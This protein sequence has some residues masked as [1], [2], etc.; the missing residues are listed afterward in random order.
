MKKLIVASALLSTLLVAQEY[1][2]V[3]FSESR[4]G[5]KQEA[6]SD[7]SM[8]IKSE[9][10][11]KFEK[12]QKRSASRVLDDASSHVVVSSNLPI[13]G[14]EYAFYPYVKNQVEADA[15][16]DANV[17][18]KAYK[19]KLTALLKDIEAL[20]KS[21]TKASSS[22]EKKRLYHKLLS[23]L[24]EYN[25]YASVA[26]IVGVQKIQTPSITKAEVEA[27]LIH[28]TS[29]LDSL[30]LAS[31]ELAKS[32]QKESVFLYPP[33][34][35][36][37]HEVSEFAGALYQHLKAH[38]KTSQH[39]QSAK[40]ILIGDYLIERNKVLVNYTLLDAQN[41]KQVASKTVVINEQAYKGLK[42]KP[43]E[44]SLDVA[45]H[46]EPLISSKLKVS[47]STNRGD[48]N[49]LFFEGE[50]VELITK[51]NHTGYFYI[52]G[53]TNTSKGKFAYL[54][55]LEEG[56]GDDKFVHYVNASEV[57]HAVSLGSFEVSA[58]FGVE[59][60]EIIA[61]D[62]KPTQLP[63]RY[64]DAKSGYYKIDGKPEAVAT[65]TRGLIKKRIKAKR[66]GEKV[67]AEV[68]E[69]VLMFTTMPKKR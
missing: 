10:H 43:K 5:A 61:S 63:S 42:L 2:G 17:A 37:T 34:Y 59:S 35:K 58:P 62:E 20:R 29:H 68:S 60:L 46:N 45:L 57:N 65:K 3:G 31:Q 47:I 39:L 36:N 8:Q 28:L 40:Y 18:K 19:R 22:V 69:S 1:V 64:Y 49:L 54:L 13:I 26:M 66:A 11:S 56:E 50:E 24:Q 53:Y 12:L 44:S 16:L 38:I 67:K 14:A 21:L 4:K 7:L 6:L 41:H 27:K 30:E 25:R 9:V 51:L 33:K 32:F 48:E 55:E 23:Y 52:V 15:K